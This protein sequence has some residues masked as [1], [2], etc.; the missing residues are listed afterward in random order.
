MAEKKSSFLKL[1]ARLSNF[2]MDYSDLV[3]NSPTEHNNG[4]I[5]PGNSLL[6]NHTPEYDQWEQFGRLNSSDSYNRKSIAYFDR[7]YASKLDDM[8][9]YSTQDEIEEILDTLCD[10]A[11][12]YDD[13]NFFCTHSTFDDP[14]LDE[15]QL[16]LIQEGLQENFKTIYTYWGF[17]DDVS[18]WQYFKKFLIEGY[19]AF[20]IIYSTDLKSI[21]GFIDI[22][23]VSL[24]PMIKD[25]KKMWIQYKGDPMFERTL[26]DSQIIYIS[27]A[28]NNTYGRASY[29]ERL[30]RS[31]NL[32][33]LMEHSR[34]IW[35]VVNA[36]FR[37]KFIIPVGGKS[38]N[39]QKQSL[40]SLMQSYRENIDFSEDSGE[41]KVNGKAMMPFN[42]EY[43]FPETESGKPEMETV[44]SDGPD[45]SDTD[46]LKYF[47][48]KLIRVSKIPMSRFDSEGGDA[49][50]GV[51]AE[52][53]TRDEIKFGRF[54]NRLRSIFQEIIVKPLSL[55]M[56]LDFRELE[57]DAN[58]KSQ[59][60]I[61]FNKM[62]LFEEM[63]EI[64]VL[65]K[66]A[67]FIQ[68]ITQ[69]IT[70][71]NSEGDEEPYFSAEFLVRQFLKLTN[72]DLKLNKKFKILD[73]KQLDAEK[74]GKTLSDF[75]DAGYAGGQS[76]PF[77]EPTAEEAVTPDETTDDG[78]GNLADGGAGNAVDGG[79]DSGSDAN[80][81]NAV[82][83]A[84][85]AAGTNIE[86]KKVRA[87]KLAKEKLP[88]I[89]IP[90]ADD[91]LELSE[92]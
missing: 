4:I 15:K 13:N 21:I 86:S 35:A 65:D 52:G 30:I 77:E 64:E 92:K 49:V 7:P 34:I 32:M 6:Q 75:D 68:K 79:L 88:N 81:A 8:R 91:N 37:T 24:M 18:A 62:N 73:K 89:P 3:V 46:S 55:Q 17:N 90:K 61:T 87:K 47:R 58:F 74:E 76:D 43:W 36:S 80:V 59:I 51:G 39:R 78:T 16:L 44:A 25:N 28:Q 66:R 26:F 29:L 56:S 14:S 85:V 50:F 10:E 27:Y 71:K 12:V 1:M 69:S 38:K 5:Q 54:V 63:K 82:N 11:I 33:R 40:A 31:F 45:L 2:G 19:L 83:T 9:R 20:E 67:S 23:P 22:D 53:M 57:S 60:G 41:L 48:N 72:E 84:S 42:K 70:V